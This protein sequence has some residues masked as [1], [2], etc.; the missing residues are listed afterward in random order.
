MAIRGIAIFGAVTAIPWGG[1]WSRI[2]PRCVGG[3]PDA[4]ERWCRN[5]SHSANKRP[6]KPCSS[7]FALEIKKKVSVS[8]GHSVFGM[9]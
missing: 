5:P 6:T 7:A 3:F 1:G 8:Y 2:T 9:W 4:T